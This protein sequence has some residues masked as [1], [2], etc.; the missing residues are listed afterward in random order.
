M[1]LSPLSRS[2]YSS[3]NIGQLNPRHGLRI[4]GYPDEGH[5]PEVD[6]KPP[7]EILLTLL[8]DYSL[9]DAIPIILVIRGRKRPFEPR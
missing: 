2:P 8:I 9:T 4:C 3:L 1:I 6:L 5:S 7:V